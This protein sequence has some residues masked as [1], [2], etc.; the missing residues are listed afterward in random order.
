M[1]VG[2]AGGEIHF[3]VVGE[4]DD[5]NTRERSRAIGERGRRPEIAGAQETPDGMRFVTSTTGS[6]SAAIGW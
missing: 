1:Q 5:G 6:D 4:D 2:Q 3:L